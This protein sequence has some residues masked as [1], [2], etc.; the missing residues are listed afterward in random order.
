MNTNNQ[1]TLSD[2]YNL[3]EASE[4][5]NV[6]RFD[7]LKKEIKSLKNKQKKIMI[8]IESLLYNNRNDFA[9]VEAQFKIFEANI[10]KAC[11]IDKDNFFDEDS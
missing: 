10:L 2:I 8:A 1:I 11:G 6:E 7:L 4:Q 5:K 3:L 9:C